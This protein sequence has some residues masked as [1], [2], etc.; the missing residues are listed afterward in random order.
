MDKSHLRI[1]H[2]HPDYGYV[3]ISQRKFLFFIHMTEIVATNGIKKNFEGL[4]A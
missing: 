2:M 1:I 3:A 4:M